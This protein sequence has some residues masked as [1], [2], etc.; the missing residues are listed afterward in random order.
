MD[1]E[2]NRINIVFDPDKQ[3]V[4]IKFKTEDFKTWD[5]ILGI[6]E[7]AKI[8]AQFQKQ[9]AMMIAAMN[10]QAQAQHASKIISNLRG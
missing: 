8:Q 6:L 1:T 5:Y 9:Q 7:M 10:Q 3:S 4:S 2:S